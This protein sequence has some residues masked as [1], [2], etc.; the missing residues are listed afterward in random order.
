[1]KAAVITGYHPFDVP[2]FYD[3]FRFYAGIDVYIQHI[4]H[5]ANTIPDLIDFYDAFIFYGLPGPLPGEDAPW[6]GGNEKEAIELMLGSKKGIILLHHGLLCFYDWP[7]FSGMVG[8]GNRRHK[9]ERVMQNVKIL[10]RDHPITRG[11]ENFNIFHEAYLFNEPIH[12]V[13]M[14][15][16]AETEKGPVEIAW[17]NEYHGSRVFCLSLGHDN[18]TWTNPI[19]QRIFSNGFKWAVNSKQ[20]GL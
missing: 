4:E 12:D 19:F 7:V 8:S 1:M 15:M 6:Y 13:N 2:G 20:V 16:A 5:F 10:D 18:E 14:L 3:M 9:L 11:I 17:T